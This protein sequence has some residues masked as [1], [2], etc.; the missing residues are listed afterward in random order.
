[1]VVDFVTH[2]GCVHKVIPFCPGQRQGVNILCVCFVYMCVCV[3]VFSFENITL[4]TYD[5]SALSTALDAMRK[6][7]EMEVQK[8]VAKF[9][10]EFIKKMQSTHDIGALHKEH[11]YVVYYDQ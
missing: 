11:E 9:K 7:H 3:C 8:E 6:A 10:S 4:K 5:V 2:C 1:M